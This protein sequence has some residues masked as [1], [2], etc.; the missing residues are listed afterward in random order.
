M[1]RWIRIKKINPVILIWGLNPVNYRERYLAR[2]I[3]RYGRAAT[4]QSGGTET[5]SS[6]Q[7]LLQ[8]YSGAGLL[9]STRP[10]ELGAVLWHLHSDPDDEVSREDRKLLAYQTLIV[11]EARRCGG[12]GWLV[13]D[14]HFQQQVVGDDEADWSRLKQSLY[15]VTFI[16]QGEKEKGQCCLTCLES[17]HT[18]EQCAL[19]VPP[20]RAHPSA[21]ARWVY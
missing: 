4:R 5:I 18:E 14:R 11:R 1:K 10:L 20:V 16:A 12:K 9:R 2:R 17:D 15:V 19:Y 6:E 7:L 8:E 13:Y 3:R 21:A